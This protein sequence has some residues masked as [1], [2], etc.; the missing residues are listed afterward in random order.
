M[1]EQKDALTTD[2]KQ[3]TTRKFPSN[4]YDIYKMTKKELG[5]YLNIW[6]PYDTVIIE[7][8]KHNPK[9][10]KFCPFVGNDYMWTVKKVD[11]VTSWS[12]YQKRYNPIS[13]AILCPTGA[14][15]KV[16]KGGKMLYNMKATIHS[17]DDSSFGIWISD[18]PKPLDELKDIRKKL[19]EYLNEL[20]IVNGDHFIETA[21]GLG[22]EASSVDYN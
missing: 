18:N 16:N 22:F 15:F 6:L 10:N 3:M 2:K 20:K 19:M 17:I 14:E 21:I 13:I 9:F 12:L 5:I 11:E 7:K 1:L 8:K 4:E